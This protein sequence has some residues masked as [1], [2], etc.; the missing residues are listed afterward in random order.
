MYYSYSQNTEDKR[1]IYDFVLVQS[2]G[3]L[4]TENFESPLPIEI[5]SLTGIILLHHHAVVVVTVL[6]HRVVT[7][8]DY[9]PISIY[10]HRVSMT[11]SPCC[12][13]DNIPIS[14]Y[15]HRDYMTASPCCHLPWLYFYINILSPC[16]YDCITMLSLYVIIL[17]HHYVITPLTQS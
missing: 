11:V 14:I 17:L 6:D 8:L 2:F 9:I 12:H 4:L 15:Y 16:L 1:S 10:Y 13:R 7:Y 3:F 5:L